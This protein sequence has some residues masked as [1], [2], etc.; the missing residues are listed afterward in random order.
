MLEIC[1]DLLTD[2]IPILLFLP[3]LQRTAHRKLNHTAMIFTRADFVE[4][5]RA[6]NRDRSYHF[7]FAVWR[8]KEAYSKYD[9]RPVAPPKDSCAK[10]TII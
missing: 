1:Q 4:V 6:R 9:H 7:V 10:L 3:C 2:P 5:L 8:E